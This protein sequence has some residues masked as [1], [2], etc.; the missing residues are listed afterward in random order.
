M[1]NRY[2]VPLKDTGRVPWRRSSKKEEP[3]SKA[4]RTALVQVSHKNLEAVHTMH[5]CSWRKRGVV[6][7]GLCNI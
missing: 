6:G 7:E 2:I 3:F 1:G 4:V 5:L